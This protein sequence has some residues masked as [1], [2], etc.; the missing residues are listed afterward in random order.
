MIKA[1]FDG[2]CE[3][4][5]DGGKMGYGG[6]IYRHE[7]V[8]HT[9]SYPFVSANGE[10]SNNIA[11]YCG[12]I[13]VFRFLIAHE[14]TQEETY[15]FGDSKMVIEQLKGNWAMNNGKYL[16]YAERAVQL[17]L[18]F[19]QSPHLEWIPKERNGEADALSRKINE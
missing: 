12:V 13:A 4:N 16:P 1:Y 17:L 15:I 6:I 7:E 14:L 11:E 18:D 3:P 10:A 2:C 9:I 5:R 8:I 19:K